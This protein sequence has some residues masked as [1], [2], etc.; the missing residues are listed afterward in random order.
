MSR[1]RGYAE[2]F[3]GTPQH[4]SAVMVRGVSGV[5]INWLCQIMI[6]DRRETSDPQTALRLIG[7]DFQTYSHVLYFQNFCSTKRMSSVEKNGGIK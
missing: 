6:H 2:P 5:Y 3:T 4:H 7:A 1:V